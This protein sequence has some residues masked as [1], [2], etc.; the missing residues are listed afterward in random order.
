M[1]KSEDVWK[2]LEGVYDPELGYSI[3]KLGLVYRVDLEGPKPRI[4][5]TLTY[6]GCPL[7]DIL[8]SNIEA[9]VHAIDPAADLDLRLVWDPPWG[10]ERMDEGIRLELGYPL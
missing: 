5:F 3:V 1:M 4:D 8:A 7:A 2:A 6:F 9:A 10:P